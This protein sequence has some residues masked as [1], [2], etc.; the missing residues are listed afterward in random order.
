[1]VYKSGGVVAKKPVSSLVDYDVNVFKVSSNKWALRTACYSNT[2]WCCCRHIGT[3][4]IQLGFFLGLAY[5]LAYH[6]CQIIAV[7]HFIYGDG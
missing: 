3:I 6:N 5:M 4:S 2:N 1:M 7:A